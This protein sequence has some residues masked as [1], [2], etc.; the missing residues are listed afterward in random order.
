[1]IVPNTIKPTPT[2][3]HPGFFHSG[4]R[5]FFTSSC[6]TNG[7]KTRNSRLFSEIYSAHDDANT[8]TLEE[9]SQ[10]NENTDYEILALQKQVAALFSK[11]KKLKAQNKQLKEENLLHKAEIKLLTEQVQQ[12]IKEHFKDKEKIFRFYTGIQDYVTFM[13]LFNS[14]GSAV[15]N[16]IFYGMVQ[17]QIPNDWFLKVLLNTGPKDPFHLNK[18]FF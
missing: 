3:P 7:P 16:L 17:T 10:P 4:N 14:F 2:N 1:M 8:A 6:D 15:N 9:Q 12:T 11:N 18:N 5:T 13:T